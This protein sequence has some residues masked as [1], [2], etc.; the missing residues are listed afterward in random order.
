MSPKILI[1]KINKENKIKPTPPPSQKDNPK[2]EFQI[3]KYRYF[4]IYEVEFSKTPLK[5]N[6]LNKCQCYKN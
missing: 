2:V 5:K 6:Y 1:T 4:I 3:F